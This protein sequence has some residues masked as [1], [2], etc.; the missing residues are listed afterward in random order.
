MKTNTINIENINSAGITIEMR[1][2]GI[3]EIEFLGAF[4]PINEQPGVCSADE[5]I[6]LYKV[7]DD[8]LVA[9]TNGDP[10]WEAQD[11]QAWGDLMDV[12]GIT[13]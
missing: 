1:R 12:Y 5:K 9:D 7:P 10:V 11:L 3:T 2:L 4:D 8:A 13:L 6:R